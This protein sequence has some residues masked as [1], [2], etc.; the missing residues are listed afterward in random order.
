[1]LLREMC[2]CCKGRCVGVVQ[3]DVL[4]LFREMCRC[5]SGRCVGV[6]KGDV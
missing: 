1:M 2:R 3:G 5:C 4:V 6:V